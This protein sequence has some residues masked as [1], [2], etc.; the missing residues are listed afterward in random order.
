MNYTNERVIKLIE[1][2]QRIEMI[3]CHSENEETGKKREEID[4]LSEIFGDVLWQHKHNE[5]VAFDSF[6][7]VESGKCLELL[8]I[9][10]EYVRLMIM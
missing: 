7:D 3:R 10:V 6:Y 5:L 1:L 9:I 8:D 2:A 4:I